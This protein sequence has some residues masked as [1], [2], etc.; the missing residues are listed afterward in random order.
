M[1][2]RDFLKM[3][4]G[5]LAATGA[6][7]LVYP[8]VR[9]LAPLKRERAAEPLSIP[10][11]DIP[12]GSSREVVFQNTPVIVINREGEGYV[13]LSRVCTHLGCL[14]KYDTNEK[15]LIC[16]C[17][18]GKFDLSGNVVSGPPPSPLRQ[19]PVRVEGEQ[20]LIG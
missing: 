17:H 6:V 10:K 7:A 19:Y 20:I 11:V 15:L 4:S 13:A 8:V 18:A 9:L 5:A 2:R 16:P 3:L 14:V 1:E 12:P